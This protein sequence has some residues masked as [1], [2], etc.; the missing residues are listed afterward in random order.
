MGENGSVDKVGIDRMGADACGVDTNTHTLRIEMY[1]K[2]RM[3]RIYVGNVL[4]RCV[5]MN[6][7]KMWR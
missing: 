7:F 5:V 2:D 6:V 4:R 1:I 3:Q